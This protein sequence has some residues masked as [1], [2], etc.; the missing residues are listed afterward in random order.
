MRGLYLVLVCFFSLP[1][2]AHDLIVNRN[3][4][5]REESSSS[6]SLLLKLKPGDELILLNHER[7]NGY[8]RAAHKDGNGWVWGRN[9]TIIQEYDRDQWKHWIDA[10][11]D[12]QN[13]RDEV[14][15]AESEI[16]VTFKGNKTCKV[17]S[18][19]WTDP[20]T[21]EVFT[22][23][24][25][26]DVDHMVPL[27]NAHR[28]GGWKWSLMKREEYANDL[29]HAEHL[30]AVKASANRS[31]GAKSPDQWMPENHDYWC[32]YIG[33]WET[34]KLRWELTMT[35]EESTTVHNIKASCQ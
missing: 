6:S 33:N 13:A 30:I 9:V 25:D 15:I 20:Y 24:G 11:D 35:D 8:Y 31:K 7:E 29:D 22:D 16:A 18:G 19:R 10:D 2:I 4:S 26:L 3:S 21:G 14:L 1:V 27:G 17:A 23:P 12:C 5:F 32:N 34:I 28:S